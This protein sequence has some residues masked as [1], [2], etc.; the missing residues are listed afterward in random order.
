MF[1]HAF[2]NQTIC[3][4]NRGHVSVNRWHIADDIPFQKS[5]DGY[6]EKYYPNLRPTLYSATVYWYLESNGS[7]PYL[8]DPMVQR[9]EY[10]VSPPADFIKDAIEGED[11]RISAVTGG[12]ALVQNMDGKWPLFWSGQSHLFWTDGQIGDQLELILPVETA[13]RYSLFA[14]FTKTP[15]SAIIQL[16]IDDAKT[17]D[18]VDLFSPVPPAASVKSNEM[19]SYEFDQKYGLSLRKGEKPSGLLHLGELELSK[20]DHVLRIKLV[21]RN[22]ANDGRNRV[23][24]DYLKLLDPEMIWQGRRRASYNS[25][26]FP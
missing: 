10:W 1:S 9:T 17:G 7:D 25:P 13:G 18:P 4:E 23:G 14:Q 22:P 6:I 5:F 15:A 24:L 21:G 2:H 26:L 16:Y 20:G 11:L 12:R 19:G 3:T 8:P